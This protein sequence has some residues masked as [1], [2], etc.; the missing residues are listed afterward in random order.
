LRRIRKPITRVNID[1][2]PPGTTKDVC[3]MYFR[4]GLSVTEISR[5]LLIKIETVDRIISKAR[6]HGA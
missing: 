2:M 1:K 3:T 6:M 4:E 5:R